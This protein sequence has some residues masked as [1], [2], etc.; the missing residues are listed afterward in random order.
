MLIATIPLLFAILGLLLF[1][2]APGKWSTLGLAT[3]TAAMVALM[4]VL[5][6]HTFR[7]G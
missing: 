6:H 7:L 5:S 1:L 3:F 2:L 4:I